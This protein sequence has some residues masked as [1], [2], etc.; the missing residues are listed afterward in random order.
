MEK[1]TVPKRGMGTTPFTVV[2]WKAREAEKIEK[3]NAVV[4]IE[5]EKV[6]HEL[7]AKT[8]GYLHILSMEGTEAPIGTVIAFIA[9]TMEELEEL[10][11]ESQKPAA[12]APQTGPIEKTASKKTDGNT[13]KVMGQE[14]AERLR[15]TPVARRLA[16]E[17]NIDISLIKGTGP[18]GSIAK[19]DIEEAISDQKEAGVDG[20]AYQGKSIKVAVPLT[21]MKKRIADN[22]KTSLSVSAQLTVMGEMD[23]SEM[24]KIRESLL[25]KE[26]SI[27][28]RIT[29]TDI[30][31]YLIAKT[32]K[33]HGL[34]NA[35]LIDNEIKIWNNINIGVATA[36]D[37]GLIVPVVKDADKKTLP[38]IS[39]EIKNLVTK[40]KNGKL[41]P[42][43]V[44]GGTFTIT[45]MGALGA[46]YRFE[47]VIINQPE[48]SIL[49]TGGITERAVVRNSEIVIRPIMTYYLTYDH[50]VMNGADAA[51]FINDLADAFENPKTFLAESL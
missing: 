36:I 35:S 16:K 2:E 19:K 8:A 28:N 7:E 25:Q 14:K 39:Q 31:V 12:A 24:I 42:D 20:S 10:Q 46:G 23:M 5:S 37:N 41:S 43:D 47:T 1:I 51:N 49:G 9:E 21:G 48:S 50:R 33:N 30:F 11:K 17:H 13:E 29:Y 32:L 3:G 40:T 44:T 6:T 22:L 34:L 26:K 18:G 4:V 45:N 38:E 27:G 15:I